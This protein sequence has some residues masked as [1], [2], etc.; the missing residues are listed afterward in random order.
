LLCWVADGSGGVTFEIGSTLGTARSRGS[1]LDGR[2][3]GGSGG[4]V[5]D[6]GTSS[7]I[8]GIVP[9]ETAGCCGIGFS[10]GPGGDSG[11][12]PVTGDIGATAGGTPLPS[13]SEPGAD[14]GVTLFPGSIEEFTAPPVAIGGRATVVEV[15]PGIMELTG[16]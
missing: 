7:R 9:G 6:I 16:D 1:L 15:V 3:E 12:F 14:A 8:I 10:A 11:R 4:G 5:R 13:R 2:V